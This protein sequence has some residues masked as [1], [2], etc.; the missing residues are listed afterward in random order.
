MK[1][2]LERAGFNAAIAG[3]GQSGLNMARKLRPDL[4]LL[5][6]MLPVISGNELC[7]ILRRESDVPIIMLT[8]KGS[9]EDRIQG[10]N[11]GADDYIV[12]PFEPEEVIVRIKAVLRRT[13]GLMKKELTCGPIRVDEER[14]SVHINDSQIQMS[15]AQFMIFSVFM[16]NPGV[17]LS[18]GQIIEQAFDG[19]FDAYERAID[20]HIRRLRKL[21]HTDNFEPIRTVYGG[22]YKLVCASH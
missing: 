14:E 9:T 12:K 20:T 5:D 19:N 16:N 8:A 22:G 17:V 4:I 10:I 6:L 13:M 1:T 15:H 21:L 11:G 7:G 2:Y 18:R 3:D